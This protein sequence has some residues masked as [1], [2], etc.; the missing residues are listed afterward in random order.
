MRF[1]LRIWR[2][3][4][5]ASGRITE[6]DA[7]MKTV[8]SVLVI[9]AAGLGV[10]AVFGK[11][12][13]VTFS[14]LF[15]LLVTF[16]FGS[17]FARSRGPRLRVES[18]KADAVHNIFSVRVENLGP[19]DARPKVMLTNLT[20]GDWVE[21]SGGY[22]KC[23][24][25][26]RGESPGERPLMGEGDDRYAGPLSVPFVSKAENPRLHLYPLDHQTRPLWDQKHPPAH[27]VRFTLV[28]SCQANDTEPFR[29]Q[30]RRSYHLTP[31]QN[32]PLK[33][34]IKRLWFP[35]WGI[36]R[37]ASP[38]TSIH[39][40]STPTPLPEYSESKNEIDKNRDTENTQGVESLKA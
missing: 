38:A 22:S 3:M 25:H 10:G 9:L 19:G 15:A 40:Q 34:S 5:W 1:L 17:V 37:Q 21:L 8:V 14:G 36:K 23:E 7:V 18:L 33:Y 24:S 16:Y 6:I 2:D 35:R 30:Q 39:A 13:Y 26:W 32:S 4:Q 31:D 11:S 20:D 12:W 29:V 28:T 27:G